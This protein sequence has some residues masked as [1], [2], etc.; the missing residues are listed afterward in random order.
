LTNEQPSLKGLGFSRAASD[1]VNHG[2]SRWGKNKK[3]LLTFV[4]NCWFFV[5]MKRATFKPEPHPAVL[6]MGLGC[7]EGVTHDYVRHGTILGIG[8]PAAVVSISRGAII[9][10]AKTSSSTDPAARDGP[11]SPTRWPSG[12]M[13]SYA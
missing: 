10:A 12:T 11:F 5:S 4:S 1:A 2:F 9:T 8:A 7:V 6:P 13:E 3:C